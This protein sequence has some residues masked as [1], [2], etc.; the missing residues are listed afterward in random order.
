MTPTAIM[1]TAKLLGYTFTIS[2]APKFPGTTKQAR[3]ANNPRGF[4][5][6]ILSPSGLGVYSE[7]IEFL[8]K[9]DKV[10]LRAYNHPVVLAHI[11]AR[12]GVR[13]EY[14]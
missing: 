11:Q 14:D 9:R 13:L 3:Q 4:K 2:K 12:F 10:E 6:T 5:F 7:R 1:T 8:Y